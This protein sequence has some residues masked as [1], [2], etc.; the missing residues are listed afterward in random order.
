MTAKTDLRKLM[1]HQGLRR[2]PDIWL[3]QSLEEPLK[4][5][6]LDEHSHFFP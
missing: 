2:K 6:S 3:F 1:L 5:A 4:I